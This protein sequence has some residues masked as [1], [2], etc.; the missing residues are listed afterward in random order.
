MVAEQRSYGNSGSADGLEMGNS[1]QVSTVHIVSLQ[2]FK[3]Q[4]LCVP[5][6]LTFRYSVFVHA[7]QTCLVWV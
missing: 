4:F 5:A 6:A 3:A 2:S 1:S 7:V